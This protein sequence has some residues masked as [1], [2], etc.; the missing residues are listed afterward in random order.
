MPVVGH[1][2]VG[3]YS[4]V[5]PVQKDGFF[6][7]SLEGLVV[8]SDV[9]QPSALRRTVQDVVDVP[10]DLIAPAAWHVFLRAIAMPCES[11]PR[12]K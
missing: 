12:C 2:A 1:D 9:E 4:D 3:E 8:G 10:V 11:A 6:Q 7:H 5:G